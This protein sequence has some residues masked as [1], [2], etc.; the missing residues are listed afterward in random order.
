M[1][2]DKNID[3]FRQQLKSLGFSY[4][5]DREVSTCEPSYYK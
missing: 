2:T 1:T 3:R 5:W 4:D